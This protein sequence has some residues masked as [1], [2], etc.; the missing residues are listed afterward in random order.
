MRND[1]LN[2]FKAYKQ[3]RLKGFE[4]KLYYNMRL[5]KY[6]ISYFSERYME[7]N[8]PYFKLITEK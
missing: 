8:Y 6:L 7:K 2:S 1:F 3:M 4:V 5:N